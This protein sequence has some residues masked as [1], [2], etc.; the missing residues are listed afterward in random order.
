M[1]STVNLVCDFFG[2]VSVY[3]RELAGLFSLGRGEAEL[4]LSTLSMG[5]RLAL[6]QMRET[7]LS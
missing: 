3:Q 4:R 7:P 2:E 1:I 6:P 5:G